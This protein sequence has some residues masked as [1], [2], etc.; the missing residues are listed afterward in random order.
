VARHDYTRR[1]FTLRRTPRT[2]LVMKPC[3]VTPL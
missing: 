2:E 1:A 3:K